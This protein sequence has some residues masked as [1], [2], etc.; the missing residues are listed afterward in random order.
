MSTNMADE[1]SISRL[2]LRD[3]YRSQSIDGNY[4]VVLMTRIFQAQI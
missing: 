1:R 2:D 3:R 4:F